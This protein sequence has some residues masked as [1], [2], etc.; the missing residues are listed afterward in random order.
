V[1]FGL[2][3]VPGGQGLVTGGLQFGLRTLSVAGV[4][5]GGQGGVQFGLLRALIVLVPLPCGHGGVQLGFGLLRSRNVAHPFAG[6]QGG[7]QFG[8]RMF[9][10]PGVV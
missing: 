3:T 2:R 1:Q 8:L 7:V 6:G 4:P 10:V 5:A 9:N